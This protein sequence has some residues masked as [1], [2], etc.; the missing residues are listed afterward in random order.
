MHIFSD[1]KGFSNAEINLF[2]PFTLLI[3]P[4]GSGKSNVI[5]AIELF[6]FIVHGKPL[7]EIYDIGRGSTGIEIRGGIKGCP[8]YGKNFFTFE[9]RARIKFLGKNHSMQYF[10]IVGTDPAKILS[11]YLQVGDHIIFST[12]SAPDFNSTSDDIMVEYKNF[13]RGGKNPHVNV[14]ANRSVISQYPR[15]AIKNKKFDA[16]IALVNSISNY[17]R[18][19]FVFDPIPKQMRSY[20]RI[21]N[22]ILNRDG[23]NISSVLYSLSRGD[24]NQKLVLERLLNWI[25]QLP[26]E[27]YEAIDF[28]VTSLNDVIFGFKNRNGNFIDA[29]SLSDGTLR[30]LAV[31]TAIETIGFNSRVVVEEFDNG[32]HPSRIQVLTNAI[33]ECCERRKLNILVTT[34][35]PATL[36]ALDNEQLEGVVLTVADNVEGTSKLVRL[37]DLP[38]HDELLE[39]GRLGDLITQRV[40]ERYLSPTFEEE[41]KEN[42]LKWL[43]DL[44]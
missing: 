28:V 23:S 30:C 27:P 5:E 24:D 3:G 37:C 38:R 43:E 31:L 17:L 19:S 13:A 12:V 22:D 44:P 4:N 8:T 7:H 11:E 18:S 25:K 41:R 29:R 15:F 35:N 16:C 21:G 26:D 34:H 1:F 32:V 6:S 10:V 20:D 36:N 2:N 33:K 40:F 14:S 9:F 39:R 42:V